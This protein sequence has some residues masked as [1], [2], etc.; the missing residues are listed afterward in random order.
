M[1][2]PSA[3]ELLRLP[4]FK[5]VKRPGVLTSLIDKYRRWRE[6]NPDDDQTDVADDIMGT[7]REL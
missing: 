3:K 6:Q 7:I 1:Q 2:R 5:K 4:V